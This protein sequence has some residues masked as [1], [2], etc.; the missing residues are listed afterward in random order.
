MSFIRSALGQ[1]LPSA[2]FILFLAPVGI[3]LAGT[4]LPAFGWLPA[5][6]LTKISIEPWLA[7]F[8][9]PGF[10]TALIRTLLTGL[11]ASL[12]AVVFAYLILIGLYGT[13]AL[14]RLERLLSPLLSTPHAA[15]AIG[16]GLLIAPSGWFFRL[17]ESVFGVFP[18]PP[19]WPTFQ[20]PLGLS[21]MAVLALKE[22]PFLLFVALA[23][24][25]ALKASQTLWL[26]QTMGH[27][28]H[29][30]WAWLIGPRLYRQIKLPIMA[31]VVYSLT[32]VDIA[33]I[34]GPTIPPTLAVLIVDLFNDPNLTQRT[35][36]AAGAILLFAVIVMV[37][38][39]LHYAEHPLKQL[40]SYQLFLGA[41]GTLFPWPT[42]FM[43]YILGVFVLGLYLL[44]FLITLAWSV[45]HRWRYPDLLPESTSFK[46]MSRVIIDIGEPLGW[47]LLLGLLSALIATVFAIILLERETNNSSQTRRW[48]L[49]VYIPLLIPQ[50]AFLFGFQISLIR[51]G[52]D[53][54][55]LGL[56][57]SHLIFVFPYVFLT[58]SEPYRRI[59]PR[60]AQQAERLCRS[61]WRALLLIKWP[62]LMRPIFYAFAIGFS[63]SLVQYLPTLFVGAGRFETITTEA[64][65]LATGSDR[66]MMAGMALMQQLLPLIVFAAA[67]LIPAFHFRHRRAMRTDV[68]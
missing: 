57:W 50:V 13:P 49:L 37:L 52:L 19:S 35:L 56:L 7:V 43:G 9:Y 54:R 42:R 47:T 62:M 23:V 31:V 21:L 22:I 10:T 38:L 48:S 27:S 14:K 8:N 15:F 65:N 17:M 58:L 11:G 29:F 34:A 63:V 60:Y 53:G 18:F 2:I 61:R 25:P 44:S 39:L 36:G 64:V 5:L 12:L 67:T 40:R 20:D 46:A 51:A 55:F 1:L 6:G 24:L 28:K 59:D 41:K 16:M 66:R 68:S 26:A 45:T 33:L 3:G 32:V 4:L 30:A